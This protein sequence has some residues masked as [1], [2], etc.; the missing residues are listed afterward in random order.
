M[1]NPLTKTAPTSKAAA[2]CQPFGTQRKTCPIYFWRDVFDAAVAHAERDVTREQAGFLL[3]GHYRDDGDYVEVDAFLPAGHIS[4]NLTS[5]KFTHETWAQ[6][7]REAEQLYPEKQVVGWYHSH[8]GFGVFLSG[9]DLFIHRHFF[10]QPW[11]VSLVIDPRRSELALFGW[12]DDD[13]LDCG[14]VCVWQ[15]DA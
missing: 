5:L 13:I 4:S 2:S 1:G 9:R 14:F 7:N 11:Q 12:Q 6:L 3:G 8:P 10:S 15:Q